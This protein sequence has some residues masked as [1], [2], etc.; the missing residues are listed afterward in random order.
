MPL[1]CPEPGRPPGVVLAFAQH[2]T[3]QLIDASIGLTGAYLHGSAALGG[4]QPGRSDVDLLLVTGGTPPRGRLAAAA[5]VLVTAGT[6][7]SPGASL[8]CSIVEAAHAL[9]PGAPWP[10]LLHVNAGAQEQRVV[11]GGQRPGDPDLL[12]HYAV[13]RAAGF[14]VHGPS[15]DLVIGPVPRQQI[16]AYLADEL[17]WGLANAPEQYAVLNACRALIY[18]QDGRIVSKLGGGTLALARGLG[19]PAIIQRGLDQ[20]RGLLPPQ[21]PAADAIAFV[22]TAKDRITAEARREPC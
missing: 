13:C 7:D 21:P 5:D 22:T 9:H 17:S 10:Y 14:A 15:P 12:I 19:P 1:S 3:S 16:L 11:W 8:E 2:L 18:A 20:Q 6:T 4:W